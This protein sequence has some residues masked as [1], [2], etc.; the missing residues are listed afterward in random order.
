MRMLIVKTST[1]SELSNL[2]RTLHE[3]IRALP[4]I[5]QHKGPD[6]VQFQLKL[7]AHFQRQHDRAVSRLS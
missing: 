1:Q 7:I 2:A 6:A 5:R 3:L 4:A